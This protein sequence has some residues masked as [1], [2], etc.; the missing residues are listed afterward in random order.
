MQ[1]DLFPLFHEKKHPV[2]KHGRVDLRFLDGL[3]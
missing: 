2:A 3:D 1:Q